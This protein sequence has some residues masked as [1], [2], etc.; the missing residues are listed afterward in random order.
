MHRLCHRLCRPLVQ[1]GSDVFSAQGFT[2]LK[3]NY[4]LGIPLHVRLASPLEFIGCFQNLILCNCRPECHSVARCLPEIAFDQKI[5]LSSWARGPLKTKHL[6]S[7]KNSWTAML[8]FLIS[9]VKEVRVLMNLSTT[10]VGSSQYAPI[11]L[12]N[13]NKM[14]KRNSHNQYRES[15]DHL[16]FE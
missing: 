2:R 1:Q 3:S 9:Q 4:L 11:I 14:L 8:S 7:S 6:T 10:R 15:M 16:P 5:S 12:C 13:K